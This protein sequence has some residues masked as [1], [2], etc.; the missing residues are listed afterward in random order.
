[1]VAAD[2]EKLLAAVD[3]ATDQPLLAQ[4]PAVVTDRPESG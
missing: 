1:V 2:G 3:A 4:I